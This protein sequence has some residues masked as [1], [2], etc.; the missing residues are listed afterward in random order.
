MYRVSYYPS[1]PTQPQEET[2]PTALA[3]T[4][5]LRARVCQVWRLPWENK[6]WKEVWWRLIQHGVVGAGGH[7]WPMKRGTACLVAGNTQLRG[8]VLHRRYSYRSTTFGLAQAGAS[9]IRRA[10]QHNLPI[11]VQLLPRHVWLLEQPCQ[12]VRKEVWYVV[13]L[14]ALTAMLTAR[15]LM[16]STLARTGVEPAVVETRAVD[17]LLAALKDFAA[18]QGS[19]SSFSDLGQSHPVVYARPN[20][21]LAVSLQLPP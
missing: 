8:H 6:N 7:G 20:G 9:A 1:R 12:T 3:I 11:S 16:F 19:V 10:I 5:A 15:G 14:A 2:R 18:C 17:L 13:C 21:S 4:K